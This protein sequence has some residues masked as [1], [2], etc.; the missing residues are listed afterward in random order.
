MAPGFDIQLEGVLGTVPLSS[1]SP[2]LAVTHQPL[3]PLICKC[4]LGRPPVTTTTTPDIYQARPSSV[5]L[6]PAAL[7][8]VSLFLQTVPGGRD[9]QTQ[10]PCTPG[11]AQRG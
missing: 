1:V 11:G 3:G 6:V 5:H 7:A 4:G 10:Y 9:E 8:H 2:T